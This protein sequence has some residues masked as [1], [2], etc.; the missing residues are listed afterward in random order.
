MSLTLR[1]AKSL[2]ILDFDIENRPLT[3]WFGDVTTSEITAIAASWAHQKSVKVWL[4]PQVTHNQML[5]EFLQMYD[6][7]DMVTGHYIRRHDLPTINS[8]LLLNGLPPLGEKLTCDTKLDLVKRRGL[9]ASQEALADLLGIPFGKPGMSQAHWREA[10]RLTDAGL[11]LVK[12]RVVG[13]VRQHKA[14]REAL[15]KEGLLTTP[16]VWRP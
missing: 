13:D 15:V 8:A 3:Y 10:N 1:K 6:E 9:P 7:A 11:K 14:L 5:R 12:E 16:K 2:K 4:L